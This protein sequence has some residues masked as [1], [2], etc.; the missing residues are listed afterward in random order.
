MS[1]AGEFSGRFTYDS[2][3]ELVV[4]AVEIAPRGYWPWS[5]LYIGTIR[6]VVDLNG[7]GV[8]VHCGQM[9]E[10][11]EVGLRRWLRRPARRAVARDRQRRPRP[12]VLRHQLP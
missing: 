5:P 3:F 10:T 6:D 9:T 8:D 11:K 2:G 7:D 12:A 4:R 1:D